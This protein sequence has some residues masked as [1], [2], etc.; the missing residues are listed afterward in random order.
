MNKKELL[1]K[2]LANYS[3]YSF[4][5]ID[6]LSN[7]N[8]KSLQLHQVSSSGNK[9][10]ESLIKDL[11]EKLI[12][13]YRYLGWYPEQKGTP[14]TTI[15]ILLPLFE[16]RKL[17]KDTWLEMIDPELVEK[18]KDDLFVSLTVFFS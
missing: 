15:N 3:E 2:E 12:E 5:Y 16:H 18:Q 11:V 8:P 10:I 6:D 13:N 9:S 14:Y 17:G 1:K 4:N 7:L